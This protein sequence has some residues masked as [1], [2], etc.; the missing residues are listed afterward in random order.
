MAKRSSSDRAPGHPGPELNDKDHEKIL[1][2]PKA[3]KA[4]A[5]EAVARA[6]AEDGL[7]RE[8]AEELYGLGRSRVGG[9]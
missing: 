6:M 3:Q 8:L 9:I 2:D 1:S 5:I 7:S 4:A